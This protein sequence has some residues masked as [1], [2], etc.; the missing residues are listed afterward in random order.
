MWLARAAALLSLPPPC[1]RRCAAKDGSNGALWSAAAPGQGPQPPGMGGGS[2][3]AGAGRT[4]M[5]PGRNK[6]MMHPG[7]AQVRARMCVCVC[8]CVCVCARVCVCACAVDIPRA[9]ACDEH[10]T[11]LSLPCPA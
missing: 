4:P 8:V 5:P 1:C 10:A 3:L 7:G 6:M 2:L 9:G 11:C